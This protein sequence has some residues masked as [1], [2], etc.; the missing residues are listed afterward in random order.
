M[1][2]FLKI[3]VASLCS[4]LIQCLTPRCDTTLKNVKDDKTILI[5]SGICLQDD[6][7]PQT[8]FRPSHT[9]FI[10]SYYTLPI[11]AFILPYSD[12][13][14]WSQV[15]F[16]QFQQYFLNNRPPQYII[17]LVT[18]IHALLKKNNSV[19]LVNKFHQTIFF[20]SFNLKLIIKGHI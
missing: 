2:Q 13:A 15:Q 6:F 7:S 17:Q 18:L 8:Y 5:I 12:W 16:I 19:A 1:Q 3:L 10:S 9:I 14:I 11:I 20:F 4:S